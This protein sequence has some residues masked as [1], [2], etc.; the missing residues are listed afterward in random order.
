[1]M[2]KTL[3]IHAEKL[4]ERGEYIDN[5]MKAIGMDYEFISEGDADKLTDELLDRY[6]KD[7]PEDLHQKSSRASCTIKHF[8][9]YEK[10][11]A[12][13][14]EGALI[15]EDDIVLHDD[16][17]EKFEQS[18]EE[19][20]QNYADRNV[21]ISYEDSSLQFV[22]RS[23]RKK[24]Q[25]LYYGKKDR[26]A[27]AYY[28][29]RRCAEAILSDLSAHKCHTTDAD[30]Y[31]YH[32]LKQGVI[33]YLWCQPALATQGSFTGAFRSSLS[34][35]KDRMIEFRWW[36]KKNYKRLLYWFR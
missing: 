30:T 25:L 24:G 12:D 5:M 34:S 31:H 1:M 20:R 26:M 6:L 10:I 36:F 14:L 11:L 35:K 21:L 16:F 2:I 8:L 9:A 28:M 15:L 29:S 3:I 32:L 23:Q 33:D 7:G 18:I 19:Y 22:P 17:K 27:G 4:K 13:G